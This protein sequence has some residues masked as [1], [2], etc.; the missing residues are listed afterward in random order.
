MVLKG[1]LDALVEYK[2]V[3]GSPVLSVYLDV[4][5]SEMTNINRGFEVSL[6]N[7][8]REIEHGL[9]EDNP[10]VSDF[11]ED[12]DRVWEYV[13]S[14]TP[15]GKGL[16]AMS[17]ASEGY[18]W[19]RNLQVRLPNEVHWAEKPYVRPL[20]EARD[21]FARY[22]VILTDKR[23]ARLFIVFLNEVEESRETLARFRVKQFKSPGS[24][25]I[26]SQMIFQRNADTHAKWHLKKVAEMMA[27][28]EEEQEFERLI[29]GGPT[30]AVTV[31]ETLL[32]DRLRSRLIGVASLAVEA[33]EKEI[34]EETNRL[35]QENQR[36]T[37][38]E[39]VDL[40]LTAAGKERR[41][42]T[43][44]PATVRATV[45]GRVM[46]LVYEEGH[47]ARG[48]ECDRCGTLFEEQP[49]PWCPHCGGYIRPVDDLMERL[50][51]SAVK[52]GDSV[53]L[54]RGEAA[55]TLEREGGGIGAFLRF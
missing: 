47:L 31:L 7:A 8:L 40:L 18:F 16:V 32:T 51:E 26:W 22:G 3:E 50:V 42:V 36:K 46:S 19:H 29:I 24:D 6:K 38:K 49:Q 17:D 41:A 15:T 11:R 21:E 44:L 43:G 9:G 30:E 12:S 2:P 10:R 39:L 34:L 55:E 48:G 27:R 54:V 37:E 13:S 14:F 52:T 23:Q 28:L 4:D 33:S 20:V 5:Q 45:E 53:E 35:E 1:D 25:R